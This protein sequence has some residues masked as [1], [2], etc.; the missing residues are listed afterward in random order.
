[1]CESCR[2]KIETISYLKEVFMIAPVTAKA[3]RRATRKLPL[4]PED[5]GHL[6]AFE[7]LLDRVRDRTRSVA[8]H[9][10]NGCYLAGRAGSGKS[11]SVCECLKSMNVPYAYRNARMSPLGLWCFIEEH[12]E[13]VCVIDDIPTLFENKQALQVLM[14]ALGGEPGEPRTMTYTIK[15]KGERK[16]FQFNGGIIAISNLPLNRDP[17]ADAVASR[18]VVLEHEPSDQ[19]IA[20]FMRCQAIQG[21]EGMSPEECMEVVEFVIDETRA[22][23]HRLDL[24]HMK[25]AWQDFR[26]DKD[27]KARRPWR[28][29]VRT[30]LQ[31]TFKPDASPVRRVDEQARLREIA[32]DLY[33]RFP[34]DKPSRDEQWRLL[35]NKSPDTLCRRFSAGP[36]RYRAGGAAFGTG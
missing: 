19:M 8:L 25:K 26:Q 17:L 6:S 15:D 1:M 32:Q 7:I 5:Q 23:D 24:R 3:V 35:T 34:D 36:N 30:S 4:S 20:A 13:H 16:S 11:Y 33:K 21:F 31:K 12:P 27:G 18:V 14:A 10:Q 29:L 9:Y 2:A 28:E 22:A